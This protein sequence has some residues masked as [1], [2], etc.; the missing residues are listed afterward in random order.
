MV[1]FK[2]IFFSLIMPL[3]FFNIHAHNHIEQMIKENP[4]IV[5]E[6]M[7]DGCSYCQYLTPLFNQVAAHF[8]HKPISFKI[9][10]INTLDK[11]IKEHFQ[12][13]TYP[14]VIYFKDGKEQARHGSND[15]KMTVQQMIQN[16]QAIYPS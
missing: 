3:A 15:K 13:K 1:T 11:S 5:I 9:I 7:R 6:F 12:L 8:A 4:A 2:K 14:T 16:I 10:N